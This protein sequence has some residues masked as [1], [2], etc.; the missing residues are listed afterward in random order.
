MSNIK[1]NRARNFCS[2]GKFGRSFE[3]MTQII[4]AETIKSLTSKQI[5]I[6]I[7]NIWHGCQTAKL[8]QEIEICDQGYIWDSKRN[9]MR[10]LED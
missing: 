8:I 1:L 9:K 7:D 3:A 5:A 2:I 6:L 4:P 10:E